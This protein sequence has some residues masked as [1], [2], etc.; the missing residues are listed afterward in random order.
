MRRDTGCRLN[1]SYSLKSIVVDSSAVAACA[2]YA[3]MPLTQLADSEGPTVT[4]EIAPSPVALENL[5]WIDGDS[6]G[7]LPVWARFAVS[8]GA[9]VASV[10]DDATRLVVG[11][12]APDRSFLAVL[13]A[14]GIV[15]AG[16]S[17]TSDSSAHF[18]ELC[19]LPLDTPVALRSGNRRTVGRLVGTREQFGE[20]KIVIQLN[21]RDKTRHYL[22]ESQ[23]ARVQVSDDVRITQRARRTQIKINERFVRGVLR[24]VDPLAFAT[25]PH[26]HAIIVSHLSALRF[27]V[28]TPFWAQLDGRGCVG[29]LNDL[30]GLRPL[31]SGGQSFRTGVHPIDARKDPSHE[32]TDRSTVVLFD[33]S[34]A[35]LKW[36]HAFAS[37]DAIVVLSRTE[38][39]LAEASNLLN[40][41]YLR[42][43]ERTDESLAQLEVP[44]SI[45][46]MT[47]REVRR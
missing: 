14:L 11:L 29:T 9:H 42:R 47:Y 12:A 37:W 5:S 7:V 46:V 4:P 28:Q 3:T 15:G 17:R 1:A 35:F 21:D 45:E 20:L 27:E 40:Q 36:Q 43:L 18:R 10:H 22:P 31:A 44:S 30:L 41:M 16:A 25:T 34:A 38:T 26:V 8:L 33:G 32:L 6:R 39:R 24:G 13:G 19:S 23:S 2:S